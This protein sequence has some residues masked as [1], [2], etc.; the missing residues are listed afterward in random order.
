MARDFH[1]KEDSF[2]L[3]SLGGELL[4]ARLFSM[5]RVSAIMTHINH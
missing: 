2:S 1:T 3:V 4:T 5:F